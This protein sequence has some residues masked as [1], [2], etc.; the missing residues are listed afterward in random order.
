M[1]MAV[2]YLPIPRDLVSADQAGASAR[3]RETVVDI[4]LLLAILNPATTAEE[5]AVLRRLRAGAAPR[6]RCGAKLTGAA[7]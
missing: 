1:F 4:S 5:E 3:P 7:E 6:P 2:R